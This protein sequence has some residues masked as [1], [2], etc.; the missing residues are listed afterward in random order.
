MFS[1]WTSLPEDMIIDSPNHSNLDPHTAPLW[2]IR[3]VYNPQ[4]TNSLTQ[5]LISFFQI[6]T[7]NSSNQLIGKIVSGSEDKGKFLLSLKPF[8][9]KTLL[10]IFFILQ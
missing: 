3:I 7:L 2:S 5:S 1:T 4:S 6:S 9:D 10:L 8:F